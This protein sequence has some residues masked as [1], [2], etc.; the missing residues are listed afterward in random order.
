MERPRP[1]SAKCY[2]LKLDRFSSRSIMTT[3][4]AMWVIF[5]LPGR[6]C[7]AGPANQFNDIPRLKSLPVAMRVYRTFTAVVWGFVTSW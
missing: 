2:R 1:C 4:S 7:N 3:Q 6:A 5:C